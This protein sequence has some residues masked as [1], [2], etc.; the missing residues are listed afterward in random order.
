[1]K[2]LRRYPNV[3]FHQWSPFVPGFGPLPSK[4]PFGLQLLFS[5][6]RFYF[7]QM[8]YN[9]LF[10][11]SMKQPSFKNMRIFTL[12]FASS[13]AVSALQAQVRKPFTLEDVWA[14]PN[15]REKSVNDVNWL[16]G[17][18]LYTT[19]EKNNI[20]VYDITT[21]K[22]TRTLLEGTVLKT[23]SMAVE[24]ENYTINA[25]AS[26]VLIETEVEPIYR[27]SSRAHFFLYN[28]AAKKL[29]AIMPGKKI[30]LATLSPDGKMVAFCY[31]NNL[32]LYDLATGKEKAI[33]T[34]G[35]QNELIH[36]SSDW[37]YE[38]EFE[39]WQ[40]FHWSP[41]SRKI[42]FMS[43][44]ESQ[45]PT[46]N[47]QLWGGLYPRDYKFKYPKA[48]EKNSKVDISIYDLATGNTLAL[49]EG[50]E[51]D[52]YIARMQWT[53]SANTLSF[54]RMNRL[55]NQIELIHADA[56][57]GTLQTVLKENAKTFFEIN[58]DLVYLKNGKQFIY[59]SD[60]SGYPHIYLYDIS[61][62][63]I[64]QITSGNWE[65]AKF[66]GLDESKK[67]LY[68]Q[69][70][71]D[72][73]TQRHLYKIGIDGKGKTRLSQG[74]GTHNAGF[75][76]AF[77]YYID[78]YHAAGTPS[79]YGL[80]QANGKLVKTLEDNA[81]LIKTLGTYQI[82]PKTFFEITT[83]QGI[84]LNAWMIKPADFDP[85]KKYPVLMHCYGG[86]GHQT[87]TDAWA[88]PDYF[89]YQMLASKGYIIVSV[90]NRGTGGKGSDFRKATYAQMGRLECEDQIE[91]ARFLS[92]QSYV[93]GSRIG[94]WGWSFGGY[95]TSL[96]MTKGA[97]V[98]KTGIA[99][100]P[101]TNWRFYDSI[102]T[103]RYLK[104]PSENAAGYD[105]NSPVTF[106]DKLKGN[107]LIVHGTGDDNVHFQNAVA[108]VNALIKA[109]K[110]FESAY[111]PNRNHGIGG[112]STRLHLYTKMTEFLLRTL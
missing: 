104:L 31:Q 12:F 17:G 9:R 46:Y 85:S 24:I 101:V 90:D 82:S 60:I 110:P 39:F 35:K 93:D 50:S 4:M 68:Y 5:F 99:V 65:V 55:Q 1:M 91:A 41:D 95:L 112:A 97:D 100:A 57:T 67:L 28:L 77:T 59:N 20:E 2:S 70:T 69:S 72:G 78:D 84:K 32:Y 108:M 8:Y 26:Q 6:G 87:V 48:G 10:F 30:S 53:Q 37:V 54:R 16:A 63:L 23:D 19:L 71:E 42:A 64:R 38:E 27:R 49:N 29:T 52:Q 73:S 89:W 76:P 51:N 88:G 81:D 92:K 80:F 45:V 43:F 36:G 47:M 34:S 106:A 44:D 14:N 105:D 61:G 25:D 103:E 74:A 62:K 79:N 13:M 58:D 75:N 83:S 107:Y 3:F 102:Y 7:H 18:S 94:I 109:N 56:N 66:L 40:A 15:L 96:C 111:Y 86:P 33:T 11:N 98:F 22:K 21:G